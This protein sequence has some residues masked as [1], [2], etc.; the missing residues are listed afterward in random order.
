MARP[1]RVTN[2]GTAK[3]RTTRATLL[4]ITLLSEIVAS[5]V[6]P[7]TDSPLTYIVIP[8]RKEKLIKALN[9]IL[10]SKLMRVYHIFKLHAIIP[11]GP[12]FYNFLQNPAK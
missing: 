8:L 7:D 12:F 5:V 1:S 2:A 9:C 4:C 6:L 11:I 10:K 3:A